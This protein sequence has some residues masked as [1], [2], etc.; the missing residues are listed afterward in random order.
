MCGTAMLWITLQV[1]PP[2]REF[3][4]GRFLN[5]TVLKKDEWVQDMYNHILGKRKSI[6]KSRTLKKAGE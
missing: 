2:S 6:E 4:E 1:L 3:P 5:N